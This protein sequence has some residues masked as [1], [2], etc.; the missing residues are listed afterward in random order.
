[1]ELG[2]GT[3]GDNRGLVGL[4]QVTPTPA[5]HSRRHWP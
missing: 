5:F 4:G 1:M 2:G 3:A